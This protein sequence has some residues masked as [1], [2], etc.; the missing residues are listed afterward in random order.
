MHQHK[1]RS[2]H[3]TCMPS[4]VYIQQPPYI[5]LTQK[6]PCSVTRMQAWTHAHTLNYPTELNVKISTFQG[7]VVLPYA[8]LSTPIKRSL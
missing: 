8:C 7:H 3:T 6:T 4:T 1:K 2:K 5:K